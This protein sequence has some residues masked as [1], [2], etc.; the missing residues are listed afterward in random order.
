VKPAAASKAKAAPKEKAPP[1]RKPSAKALAAQAA[2]AGV[3]DE[4]SSPAPAPMVNQPLV[5]PFPLNAC[6]HENENAQA[7]GTVVT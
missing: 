3:D 6:C 1:K 7:N 5:I 2:V 4:V